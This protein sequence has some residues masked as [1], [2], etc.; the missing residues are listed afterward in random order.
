MGYVTLLCFR[1]VKTHGSKCYPPHCCGKIILVKFLQD[2]AGV[3]CVENKKGKKV[4]FKNRNTLFHTISVTLSCIY[5]HGP[6]KK[7][8][9]ITL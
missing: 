2:R 1:P 5:Y 6:I 9:N 7:K 3:R 8:K 4:V